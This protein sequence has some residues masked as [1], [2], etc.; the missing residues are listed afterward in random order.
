[1]RLYK[2]DNLNA[3]YLKIYKK[4]LKYFLHH[5]QH[6]KS[7]GAKW[8]Y[9]Y[10]TLER[11]WFSSHLVWIGSSNHRKLVYYRVPFNGIAH[12]RLKSRIIEHF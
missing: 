11:V 8:L 4:C 10:V 9:G 1:M 7:I 12:K 2:S 6:L 3:W 5:L